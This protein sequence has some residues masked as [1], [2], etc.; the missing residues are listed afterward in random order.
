ML[1][2]FTLELSLALI[3]GLLLLTL[4]Q[5][6]QYT[7]LFSPPAKLLQRGFLAARAHLALRLIASLSAS[8][9]PLY[10]LFIEAG[11]LRDIVIVLV[12][13]PIVTALIISPELS[14]T[15]DAKLVMTKPLLSR[16]ATLH[17]RTPYQDFDIQTYREL[18]T[19]VECLPQ[20]GI[21]TITL[22]S[23]MFYDTRGKL[24]NF[25]R[26]EKGLNKRRARL[27]HAPIG[28]FDC[29]LGKISM[30][31]SRD[32]R[33]HSSHCTTNRLRWHKIVITL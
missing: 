2:V 18:F 27:S 8:L 21:K 7:R 10:F 9:L 15:K 25:K 3:T 24:R 1:T 14:L 13:L 32:K 28:R 22:N 16:T 31:L 23:P 17:L 6:R 26:L 33:K 29:L 12:L 4:L 11:P 20:Y 19:L 30:L 5:H